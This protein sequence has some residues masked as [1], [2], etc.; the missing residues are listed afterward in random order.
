M[1]DSNNP[2]SP[3]PTGLARFR[4]LLPFAKPAR[5]YFVGGLLAGWVFA[6]TTGA[7][8]PAM[9][10]TVIPVIFQDEQASEEVIQFT[11]RLFGDDYREKLLVTVC[12][13][14]PVI[15]LIRGL[16]AFANRYW[17][18]KMGFIALENLRLAVFNRLQQLPLAYYQQ[19]KSGDL[20]ARLMNDTEQLR[21][22]VV[23]TSGEIIKQPLTLL[24]AVG[25]LIY[26]ALTENGVFFMLV[27]MV[28]VPV[29]VVPI[30]M[31]AKRLRKRSA[32]LMAATGDLT[33]TVTETLQAPLEIQ[34]YNLQP[35]QTARFQERIRGMLR[36]SMKTVFY[37]AVTSP[38]IEVVSAFGFVAAIYF[39]ARAGMTFGTFSALMFALW[40][41]YE[42]MKQLTNLHGHLKMGEASLD[43]LEAI[44]DA[45][46]TVPQ[47]AQPKPL[48]P[49]SS[50]LEFRN[51]TFQYAT[52]AADA[53][54]A[55]AEVTLTLAPGEV[56]ALVG[57]SGAGKSTFAMLI[58]RFYDPTGGNVTCGG[59]ELRDLDKA[60]WRERIA[61]VP[62]MPTLFNTTIAEN[63]R[64]GRLGATDEEVREAARKAYIATFIEGLPQG[65]NTMVGERGASLSGGQ[66][67]RVAIARAFLK[68]APILILDEAA[69]A[70]DSESE[71]MVGEALHELVKGRITVMIAHRF[72]SISIARR[73]LVFE[74][75]RITGD[76]T[77]D[78]L[79]QSHP[80]YRRM[81]EL[82]KLA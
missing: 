36:L 80:V 35:Q 6:L 67:Q 7:G 14:L 53:P 4:R 60:A 75:G 57:A 31:A 54:P 43:R 66:R 12:V 51:V 50:S 73:I 61:V 38:A 39:G 20:M 55:L 37:Q 45:E 23:K 16:G 21:Q 41:C 44:L 18:N 29:C 68:N 56:V 70:L 25:M 62:Q 30:R 27:I 13:L 32:Q 52:R 2:T 33:A 74:H 26:L 24:A 81:V 58:P 5:W 1:P 59:I 49:A 8:I 10:K 65:Y 48:P 22:V 11:Q 82:Q 63:I 34:A 69:S 42:P 64:A 15:F 9:L 78:A 47:P 28:S 19:H 71:A 40:A 46:D 79:A 76:G 77:P 3:A 72:S 17:L